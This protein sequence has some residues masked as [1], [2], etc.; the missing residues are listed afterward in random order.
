MAIYQRGESVVCSLKTRNSSG[1][2]VNPDTTIQ[3]T[4]T[5]GRRRNLVTGADMIN[6]G[7][8]L[9]H[10]DFNSTLAHPI[11]RYRIRYVTI[12]AART[13]ITDEFFELE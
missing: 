5:D 2:L 8:G 10:F 12:D 9:Y 4:I 13:T 1:D 3:I 11:G 7:T 6:D